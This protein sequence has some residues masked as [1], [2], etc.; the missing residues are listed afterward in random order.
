MKKDTMSI[1]AFQ[2]LLQGSKKESN[3]LLAVLRSLTTIKDTDKL[4][5]IDDIP[6]GS[7]SGW[8]Q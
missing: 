4:S 5:K 7:W 8:S 6:L 2:K 3:S 1:E